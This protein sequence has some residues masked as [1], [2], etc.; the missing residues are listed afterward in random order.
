MDTLKFFK[1]REDAV[2]PEIKTEGSV[3]YDIT[4]LEFAKQLSQDVFLFHTGLVAI[5]PKGYHLELIP[6]SSISKT[7]WSLANSVGVI[8]QDYRGEILVALRYNGEYSYTGEQVGM[9]VKFGIELDKLLKPLDM[10]NRIAQL[11]LRTTHVP[12]VEEIFSLDETERGDGGF[13]STN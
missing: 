11:I 1:L 10:P 5:A 9:E 3:G 13:G 7:D 4:I 2:I 6:R 8:D 12:P